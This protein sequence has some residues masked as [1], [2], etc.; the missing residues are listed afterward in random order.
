LGDKDLDYYLKTFAKQPIYISC[1][2][3]DLLK[4]H[5][6]NFIIDVTQCK[7]LYPKIIQL[8]LFDDENQAISYLQTK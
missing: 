4:S 6:S 7:D 1:A 2:V 8:R 5:D 3:L